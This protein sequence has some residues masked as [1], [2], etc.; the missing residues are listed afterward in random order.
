MALK[1]LM[2]RKKKEEKEKCLNELRSKDEDFQKREAELEEAVGE[3]NENS[4]EEE[5]ATVEKEVEAFDSE[6]EKHEEEKKKLEE[7]IQDIEKEMSEIEGRSKTIA[8]PQ[9]DPEEKREG[10]NQMTRRAKFFGMDVQERNEFFG[11]EQVRS[12]LGTVRA[13]IKEKRSIGNAGLLVPR[14]MLPLIRE[15]VDNESKTLKY[16]ALRMVSGTARQNVMG[17][18][19]EAI[20]TEMCKALNELDLQ[21]NN[22]EVD[23]YQVG[24]FIAVC[25]SSLDDTDEDLA[26]E[27]INALAGSIAKA[28]DKAVLFGRGTSMPLGVVTRLAQTQKPSD[29]PTTSR[30]WKDLHESNIKT[31]TGK[32]GKDLFKEI[33][34][35]SLCLNSDYSAGSIVWFMNERTHKKL[36]AESMD[37]GAAAIVAGMNGT[38][39]VIGGPIE[40]LNFIADDTIVFGHF[41]LYVMSEREGTRIESSRDAFFIQDQTV[42]KGIGR[43]DGKPAIAEAFGVMSISSSAP[44]TTATFM[45]DAANDATLTEL[46][47]GDQTVSL[48][49]N[50]YEYAVTVSGNTA[51]LHAVPTQGKASL[52]AKY[53]NK[54]VNNEGDIKLETGTK[55]LVV[56]VEQG[57]SK[58]VYTIKVTKSE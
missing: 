12:F 8:K 29:Y 7:E 14:V 37:N 3:L 39:P 54:G 20:W 28:L 23:G 36:L 26:T 49:A 40:E 5:K 32:T 25:N 22:V 47:V 10:V 2:L 6:K 43:Y 9:V 38:M 13:A 42:F 53:N 4:T 51:K 33:I 1:Q 35:N 30:E 44:V 56:T 24:G 11:N 48:Q 27:I 21:F 41:D 15:V 17:A 45:G 55:N 34:L 57:L 46:T 16:V 50:T 18:I 19:P 31:G 58:L 52:T